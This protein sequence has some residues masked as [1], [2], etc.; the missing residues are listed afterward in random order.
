MPKTRLSLFT[1][2]IL[3]AVA[4]GLWGSPSAATIVEES[5][6]EGIS[7][8]AYHTQSETTKN[9]IVTREFSVEILNTSQTTISDLVLTID[10]APSGVEYSAAGLSFGAIPPA[11]AAL[12]NDTV[13]I[14][15]D[16]SQ[17]GSIRLIWRV[18]ATVEGESILDEIAVE[19]IL[20]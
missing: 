14:T 15:Y 7:F 2:I 9:G 16:S 8:V 11:T 10:S 13:T 5:T 17:T 4:V 20:P 3:I 19:E 6:L 18:E 12:S 1:K